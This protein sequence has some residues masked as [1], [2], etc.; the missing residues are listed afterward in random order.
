METEAS[1][2]RSLEIAFVVDAGL[3]RRLAEVLGEV[4]DTLED[5]VRFSDGRT[6]Q[7]H[8]IEDIIPQPNS[9]GRTIISLTAG[10]SGRGK[11]SAFMVLR[12]NPSPSVEYT[13]NGTQKNVIYFGEKLDEWTAGIRE[14]CS[15]FLSGGPGIALVIALFLA[16]IF[17]WNNASPYLLSETVR[18]GKWAK[19]IITTGLWVV[20]YLVV[21]LF[22][23]TT[24]AIGQGR[25]RHWFFVYLRNGVLGAFLLSLFASLLASWLAHRL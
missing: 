13:V 6:V 3:L 8:D 1:K 4:G 16:P 7:F 18:T 14:W 17:F 24:F 12:D 11:Q 15:L 20:E 19:P 23:R 9:K 25:K 22:P 2:T 21:R 10:A 5:T